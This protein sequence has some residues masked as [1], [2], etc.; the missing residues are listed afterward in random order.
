MKVSVETKGE[1]ER[2]ISVTV[3]AEDV[4]T[5]YK[6]QLSHVAKD[7]YLKGFR[8]GKVPASELERRYGEQ[9][10][11]QIAL[12]VARENWP[13]A[14]EQESLK[15]ATAPRFEFS[16]WHDGRDLHFHATFECMPEFDLIDFSEVELVRPEAEVTED[17]INDVL[18][19]MRQEQTSWHPSE[20]RTS[21]LGD[22]LIVDFELID[23]TTDECINRQE[24]IERPVA[25]DSDDPRAVPPTTGLIGVKAGETHDFEWQVPEDYFG[26][27]IAG[28]QLL[29]R[30]EICEVLEPNVPE[31]DASEFLEKIGMDNLE[32]LRDAISGSLQRNRDLH[33][34]RLMRDQALRRLNEAR[35]FSLPEG[36]VIDQMQRLREERERYVKRIEAGYRAEGQAPQLDF[37]DLVQDPKDRERA[38]DYVKSALLLRKVI[39]TH[40]IRVEDDALEEAIRARCQYEP[41]PRA[42]YMEIVENEDAVADIEYELLQLEAMQY[43]VDHASVSTR[44]LPLKDLM[45]LASDD[46]VLDNTSSNEED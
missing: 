25:D 17:D 22:H 46:L 32:A 14:A 21:E 18:E 38:C 15:P 13:K 42:R 3:P 12:D 33:V 19:E 36:M 28:R 6:E 43:V 23:Q 10:R 2:R 9:L 7:A 26:E 4:S 30:Y 1:L 44:E 35:D 24:G 16:D 20:G 39:D 40:D 45:K 8:P 37:Q 34:E 41:D 31:A 29:V 5:R 27:E 11:R